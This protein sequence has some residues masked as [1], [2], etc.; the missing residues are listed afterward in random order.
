MV[1]SM[2]YGTSLSAVVLVL[3]IAGCGGSGAGAGAEKSAAGVRATMRAYLEDL[4]NN[5]PG[6]ACDLM[7]DA[8]RTNA[9]GGKATACGLRTIVVFR[10]FLDA[11]RLADLEAKIPQLP[12]AVSGDQATA[13][14]LTGSGSSSTFVYRGGRWLIS[15]S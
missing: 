12:I 11:K 15:S 10:A 4:K 3:A 6:D 14:P 2:R 7:T 8:A 9:G 13:P 5:R 1:L